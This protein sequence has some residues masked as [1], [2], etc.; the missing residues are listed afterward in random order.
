MLLNPEELEVRFEDCPF[1]VSA[2]RIYEHMTMGQ[3]NPFGRSVS[4]VKSPHDAA[5]LI[6]LV[7]GALETQ[8]C[9]AITPQNACSLHSREC[10]ESC[11][12]RRVGI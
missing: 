9:R 8:C 1:G 11:R 4:S 5:E 10:I 3:V 12:L 2:R 7:H 6:D